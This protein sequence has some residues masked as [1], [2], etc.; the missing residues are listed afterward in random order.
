MSHIV[1]I[2]TQ[3]RDPVAIA[4]ACRRLGLAAPVQGRAQFYAGPTVE[5]L[6]VHAGRSSTVAHY[7]HHPDEQGMNRPLKSHGGKQKG[8]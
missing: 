5:G 3:L 7:P 1:R 6:L 8:G 4:A 2:Q